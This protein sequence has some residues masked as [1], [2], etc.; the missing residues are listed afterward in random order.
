LIRAGGEGRRDHD[1]AGRGAA[2][3]AHQPLAVASG[4]YRVS[5]GIAQPAAGADGEAVRVSRITWAGHADRL[6]PD[7][8][9]IRRIRL[10]RDVVGE[11]LEHARVAPV[12]HAGIGV[13]PQAERDEVAAVG[14]GVGQA[15]RV[16]VAT[17]AGQVV[18]VP[19]RPGRHEDA[20]AAHPPADEVDAAGFQAV[21]DFVHA[22]S[23]A[24]LLD[25]L[26]VPD[27][28]ERAAVGI[29]KVTRVGLADAD[30]AT[31]IGQGG[32]RHGERPSDALD[33]AG[34]V[35]GAQAVLPRADLLWRE[36]HLPGWLAAWVKPLLTVGRAGSDR[37]VA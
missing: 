2:D 25:A 27:A 22:V 7:A 18:R 6:Q 3:V 19:G 30:K 21:E 31:I 17:F 10:D 15:D 35:G 37:R 36:A 5:A 11:A 8:Q 16:E 13:I 24:P 14:V 20:A 4:V 34:G 12:V 23:E 33:R 32:V 26:A 28:D 1:P 9:L 29:F